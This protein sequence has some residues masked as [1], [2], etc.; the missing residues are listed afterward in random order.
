MT[1]PQTTSVP[2]LWEVLIGDSHGATIDIMSYVNQVS[3]YYYAI[4]LMSSVYYKTTL[5]V[6]G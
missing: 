6:K 3:D 1:R 2:L 4:S 5:K